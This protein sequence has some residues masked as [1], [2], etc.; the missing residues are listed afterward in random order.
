M[1]EAGAGADS[2]IETRPGL[3]RR[4]PRRAGSAGERGGDRSGRPGR[5]QHAD[6]RSGKVTG[7]A[8]ADGR[9]VT[10]PAFSPG[11]TRLAVGDSTGH[12]TLWGGD[13][14][15][16]TGAPTGT[17][18]TATGGEP[19][20]VRALAFS[21]DRGI[22]AVGGTALRTISLTPD[23]SHALQSSRLPATGRPTAMTTS[24]LVAGGWW[25]TGG[26]HSSSVS[27]S[28]ARPK[29]GRSR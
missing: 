10:A 28:A 13:L 9:E 20:A 6:P 17:P 8:L 21:A 16:R 5:D 15:H 7:R 26:S 11:G 29:S 19:E 22:L 14:R 3:T 2:E 18:D 12:I 23:S 1:L 25:S 24:W 27:A 4:A